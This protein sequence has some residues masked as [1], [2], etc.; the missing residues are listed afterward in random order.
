MDLA[1]IQAVIESAKARGLEPMERFVRE[2][3][4]DATEAEAI[5]AADLA[6]EIIETVP[7][8]LARARQEAELR[9]LWVV[10]QPLLDHA[11][12]YFLH[13]IDLLPE[14]TQGLPGL[15]DDAYLALKILE[16]LQDGPAPLLDW[17]LTFPIAFVRR[18]VG[19]RVGRQLDQLSI[20]ALQSISDELARFWTEAAV[21]A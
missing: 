20:Q 2:R 16:T 19:E 14:M 10:V 5:D 15:L 6:L 1:G 9:G 4:P 18:L 21:Q 13:P 12:R 8:L 11:I 7:I 3:M 17:D